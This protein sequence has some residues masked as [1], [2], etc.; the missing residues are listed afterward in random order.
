[1]TVRIFSKGIFPL[2]QKN[3][4]IKYFRRSIAYY[5]F[6]LFSSFDLFPLGNSVKK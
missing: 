5:A 2:S 1:M 3:L 6:K 4:Q